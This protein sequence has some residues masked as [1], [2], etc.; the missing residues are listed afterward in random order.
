M[1]A[2]VVAFLTP[3][4]A[5]P[6]SEAAAAAVHPQEP[7]VPE[8]L[9]GS[10]VPTHYRLEL[11][12]VP[13]RETFRG[14]VDIAVE[15][16]DR[17]D[18]LWLHGRELKVLEASVRAEASGGSS[19]Q[20][21]AEAGGP[22]ALRA[23]WEPADDLG[24]AA[25]RLPEPIGPG[26]FQIRIAYEAPFNRRITGLYRVDVS[27]RAYVFTD[28]EP[29]DA[30]FMFPGFDEPSFKARYELTLEVPAE[31]VAVANTRAVG[32]EP[33]PGGLK[34]VRFAT[35]EPLP[36][37]LIALAVGPLDVMEAPPIAP[38]S[39]RG[40]PLEFR[41][42]AAHG[43]GS[44]LRYALEQ[45]PAIL[46]ALERYFGTPYPF[47][48]LD[49][50]AIPD[51]AAGAMENP[52]LI[53]FREGRLLLDE[54]N[55]SEAQKRR[56]HGITAH[57]LAHMWFGDL[58]TMAW[59]DDLWLNEGFASWMDDRTLEAL[60]PEWRV[61]VDRIE[62]L[63]NAMQADSLASAR[64][65]RQPIESHH[66]ILSA[67]DS[68]TYTKGA[69]L[70]AMFERWLGAETFR[71]G[72]QRYLAA[73]RFGNASVEDLLA[74]LSRASGKDVASPFRTFLQQPGVPLVE[75]ELVCGKGRPHLELRQSRSLPVG[76]TAAREALWQIPVCIRYG[77]GQTSRETCTLLA[78]KQGRL[79]L[80]GGEC[81]A[82]VLPNAAASGYY[83][84][85]LAGPDREA[86]RNEGWK[87]LSAA[88]RLSYAESLQ[89]AF[90]SAALPA[91]E[92]YAELALLARDETRAVAASPIKL[93]VFAR[94]HL[95]DAALRPRVE[96]YARSLYGPLVQRLGWTARPEED[97][98]AKLLRAKALGALVEIGREAQARAEAARLG[99]AY[100]GLGADGKLH[101]EAVDPELVELVL[102]TAV[103]EG[104]A[105]V[106]E[107]ALRHLKASEDGTLRFRLIK[108][109]GAATAP[110]LAA[111]ARNLALDPA[112]RVNEVLVPL[113]A[114]S[115]E[116]ETRDAVWEWLQS[117]FDAVAG[118]LGNQLG[119]A[120]PRLPSKLCGPAQA[121]AVQAFF[122]PRIEKLSGGPRSLANTVESIRLCAARVEAQKQSA[123][124]FF[125]RQ[126]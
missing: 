12:L 122:A 98:E 69:G 125:E 22:P 15:V 108:A 5:E 100:L 55:A 17:R 42:I 9:P 95:A 114:Q 113:E 49:F 11:Q 29:C 32:E 45:T 123:R 105:A 66:D 91:A 43:R 92:A 79:E 60:H 30:R 106:F 101:P 88:E 65:V 58:V 28:F 119:R 85:S 104:D 18:V 14:T 6:H 16:R 33:L 78:E 103:Q 27:G 8:R 109:L 35:T 70:L 54:K 83:R 93:L 118:R 21:G 51:Y 126:P 41:C 121:E 31:H 23:R 13:E 97:G 2:G 68:I 115:A 120:V 7:A 47:D 73:H 94:E 84:W 20:P 99:R 52:G 71:R 3:A 26:R 89:A 102:A 77:K 107:A 56:F 59:W 87:H 57:E 36:T 24:L 38:N 53:T 116:L 117:H 86:L 76:S 39:A 81:P 64:Q 37:Y 25:L 124:A 72:I 111:R 44:E 80:E 63:H 67:F 112:L 34:R 62:S 74:A 75:A 61:E 96:A 40:K 4:A 46:A 110:E 82:W 48:K 50:I 1:L 19:A 10:V 90:A